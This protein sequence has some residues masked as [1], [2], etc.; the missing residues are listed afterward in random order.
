MTT[1]TETLTKYECSW[2]GAKSFISDTTLHPI[3]DETAD[4][5]EAEGILV[6]ENHDFTDPVN[7][8]QTF[9]IPFGSEKC[10]VKELP[11]DTKCPVDPPNGRAWQYF[12]AAWAR[13]PS[14]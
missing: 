3:I 8:G 10:T 14:E 2:D 4:R 6:Y 13:R 11:K 12:L 5:F 9:C 1:P 7:C